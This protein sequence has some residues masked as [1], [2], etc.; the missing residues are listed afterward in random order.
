LRLLDGAEYKDV[1]DLSAGQRCTVI[2]PIVLQHHDRVLVIDQPEDHI[3]N[4]FIAETL[5]KSLLSRPPGAQIIVSTHNANIPVL[6][7]ANLVVHMVSDGRNGSINVAESLDDP[8]SV[9][10]ITTVMEGGLEAFESRASFYSA[11]SL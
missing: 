1:A 7:Q 8:R 4:A 9:H 5:I 2:L 6:G 11:H 10:A 3:D